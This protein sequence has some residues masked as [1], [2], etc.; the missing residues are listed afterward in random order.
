MSSHLFWNP[1]FRQII[2]NPTGS[3]DASSALGSLSVLVLDAGALG[4]WRKCSCYFPIDCDDYDIL[5]GADVLMLLI[6]LMTV[7]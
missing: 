4:V 1:I 6:F 3:V 2:A 5:V 7:L